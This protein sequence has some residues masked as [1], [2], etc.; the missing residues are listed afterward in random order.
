MCEGTPRSNPDTLHQ[1]ICRPTHRIPCRTAHA[2]GSLPGLILGRRPVP[3]AC[4]DSHPG[5]AAGTCRNEPP[6]AS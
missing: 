2:I 5:A 1:K 4:C 6:A 3:Q